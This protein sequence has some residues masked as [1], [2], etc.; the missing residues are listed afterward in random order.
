ML[1]FGLTSLLQ[2]T[3][4]DGSKKLTSPDPTCAGIQTTIYEG[5][6]YLT[7]V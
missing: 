1:L 2:E 3:L 6:L 7:E 5:L 4:R